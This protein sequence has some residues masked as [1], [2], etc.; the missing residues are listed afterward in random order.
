MAIVK[1]NS[2]RSRR[3]RSLLT[4]FKNF[5]KEE[6]MPYWK[7]LIVVSACCGA[8]LSNGCQSILSGPDVKL[9]VEGKTDHVIV[10]PE[11]PSKVDDYA[12]AELAHYLNEITG[13]EFAVVEPD[14]LT[15]DQ[16]AVF[17]GVSGPM[18]QRLG[19]DAPL[20]G[21]E[22]QEHVVRSEGQ[23]VF[24][25]GEGI[26]GNKDAVFAFLEEPLG[27]RWFSVYE[28]PMVPSKPTLVLEPFNR[29]LGYDF[30]SRNVN[31]KLRRRNLDFPYQLGSNMGFD[32]RVKQIANRYGED[33]AKNLGHFVSAVP[34]SGISGHTLFYFIP[35]TPK[36]RRADIFDWRPDNYFE[37]HPEFFSLWDNGKR[38]P[39][40]QLCFGNP[41]LRQELTRNVLEFLKRNP[42]APHF[43]LSAMDCPGTFCHCPECLKLEEKYGTPGGPLFDYLIELC[44]EMKDKYPEATVKTLAYRHSQTQTPVKLPEGEKLPNNLIIDFAPIEDCCFAD[45]KNHHDEKHAKTLSDLRGWNDIA[46]NVHAWMYPNPYRSALLMPVA[47]IERVINTIKLLKDAGV[48]GFFT[49]HIGT[50]N[51]AG[52]TDLQNYLI[53]NLMKDADCDPDE[54]IREFTDNVYGAAG[55]LM[56]DYIADVEKRR[57]AM[58]MP[59]DCRY[60]ASYEE[61]VYLTPEN[62]HRWQRQFDEMERLA[63]NDPPNVLTNIRL[64]RREL[65]FATLWKWFELKKAFPDYYQD[66]KVVADRIKNVN[67]A[68][69][70]PPTAWEQASNKTISRSAAPLGKEAVERF[71]RP[72]RSGWRG[73]TTTPAIRRNRSEENRNVHSETRPRPTNRA[74]RSR[75]RFRLRRRDRQARQPVQFRLLSERHQNPRAKPSCQKGGNQTRRI[76]TLQT[77]RDRCHPGLQNLVLEQEL[78]NLPIPWQAPVQSRRGQPLGSLRVAEVRRALLRRKSQEGPSPLRPRH[79]GEAGLKIAFQEHMNQPRRHGSTEKRSLEFASEFKRRL[80]L[81]KTK[82]FIGN[83]RCPKRMAFPKDLPADSLL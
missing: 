66:Y 9:A 52:F 27:W 74:P 44:G 7:S 78:V 70:L 16:T 56:R 24:L 32:G 34:E 46:T 4:V 54:L 49:D 31:G 82:R 40:K 76:S 43:G 20:S 14:E 29:T 12:V 83:E 2:D 28:H 47:N 25:Y 42:D 64:A 26:H 1:N 19:D 55:P 18:K 50:Y 72:H 15:E 37:T 62:I 59:P 17:V 79:L 13:A 60:R 11:N 69:P 73:E 3:E 22:A 80:S 48:T 68:K 35:P 10:K 21:L 8:L 53:F 6:T 81:K 57:I 61:L 67:E 38:L 65:D 41:E 63:A 5:K 51:R 36:T 75:R 33:A 77:R 23:D 45:W 58:P 71:H 30:P 39:N